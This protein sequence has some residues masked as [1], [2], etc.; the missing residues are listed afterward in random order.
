MDFSFLLCFLPGFLLFCFLFLFIEFVCFC[1][2]VVVVVV[3]VVEDEGSRVDLVFA[4]DL[5][6][7]VYAFIYSLTRVFSGHL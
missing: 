2:F 3:V 1:F 4:V 6:T 5:L 7:V